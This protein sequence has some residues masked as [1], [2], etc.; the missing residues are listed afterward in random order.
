M[1]SQPFTNYTMAIAR[2]QYDPKKGPSI[3]YELR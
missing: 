2:E 1:S 3:R